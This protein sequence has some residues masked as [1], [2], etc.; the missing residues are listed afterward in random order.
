G[1]ETNDGVTY[2]KYLYEMV[3]DPATAPIKVVSADGTESYY[4]S[5]DGSYGASNKLK[6]GD[7]IVLL[8][9]IDL[10]SYISIGDEV[11][12]DLNGKKITNPYGDAINSQ[13]GDVTIVDNSTLKTGEIIADGKG[14]YGYATIKAGTITG[15]YA[16]VY[17]YN[18]VIEGGTFHGPMNGT[19]FI[20]GGDISDITIDSNAKIM[21]N[22]ALGAAMND[23]V[24][25]KVEP[26]DGT[27]DIDGE[28]WKTLT[29]TIYGTGDM[30][31]YYNNAKLPWQ[32]MVPQISNVVVEEGITSIGNNAL[33]GLVEVTEISI[34]STITKI[35]IYAFENTPFNGEFTV[36]ENV[37]TIGSTAFHNSMITA[38]AVDENNKHFMAANGVL[39]DANQMVL[40]AYPDAGEEFVDYIVPDTV[41]G[42]VTGAFLGAD[43]K[44]LT[45]PNNEAFSFKP[46]YSSANA[47]ASYNIGVPENKEDY[48]FA[49]WYT[50]AE[51]ENKIAMVA[52]YANLKDS[53]HGNLTAVYA[54]WIS[55]VTLDANGGAE[56]PAIVEVVLGKA[57]GTVYIPTREGYTFG[58][59][60]TKA[61]GS[62]TV[63]TENTVPDG[64]TTYYAVW[65]EEQEVDGV[66]VSFVAIPDME[67]TGSA[68]EPVVYYMNDAGE[69]VKAE[70]VVYE[71][72]TNVGEAS[73]KV[74]IEEKEFT[75]KF[76][77]TKATI[78]MSGVSF[79]N[80]SFAY[81]GEEHSLAIEGDLPEG[82]TVSYENNGRTDFGNQ[83]VT[84]KFT[85]SDNYEAVEDMTAKLSISR[86]TIKI[87]ADDKEIYVGEAVPELTY[88]VISQV[89][90]EPVDV[91]LGFEP[92]ITCS[93]NGTEAGTFAIK[94]SGDY[95]KNIGNYYLPYGVSGAYKNGTLSVIARYAVETAEA[96]NGEVSVLPVAAPQGQTVTI[97]A[98]PDNGYVV[99]KVTVLDAEGKEVAVTKGDDG[100][101]TFV[102]P[103]SKV[104]VSATFKKASQDTP[105]NPPQDT[106]TPEEPVMKVPGKNDTEPFTDVNE[107]D[108]F[109]DAVL[110][111]YVNDIT[112]GVSDT[113]FDPEAELTRGTFLTL[114]YRVDGEPMVSADILFEDVDDAKWYA[115]AVRWGTSLGIVSG[116]P[117]GSFKPDTVISRQEMAIMLYRYAKHLDIVDTDNAGDLSKFTDA[118]SIANGWSEKPAA[119]AKAAFEWAVG[120]GIIQGMGNDTLAPENTA[121]R[122]HGMQ[123]VMNLCMEYLMDK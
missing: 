7:T 43:L 105:V 13:Y 20:K 113:A 15:D 97:T 39:F 73:D 51:Y 103:E 117:D 76:N 54:K 118:D 53:D 72:N 35:G 85:V 111:A 1:Q 65:T 34:P 89:T 45:F 79:A 49:G 21:T 25:W 64:H 24:N 2:N 46:A 99:D 12:L 31:D 11:T 92:E 67:Y 5:F 48:R 23:T 36:P 4:N 44:S 75:L 109:Y 87:V 63:V 122:A 6:D 93:A 38:F 100:K 68:L 107:K 104:T 61:D 27:V 115:D 42:F 74:T 95:G 17:G 9:N 56:E 60:N 119:E 70:N 84:A 123:V 108:W 19:L 58:G 10:R 78:D 18:T 80:G 52:E 55:D 91:E 16:A 3:P 22:V 50:E 112:K 88:Q 29:L 120:A 66:T 57:L 101:Y 86:A 90:G 116:Y 30:A 98:T 69:Q 114:L 37:E 28:E 82:V 102:M 62:G 94:V 121:T 96:E 110:F 77:I 8:D 14:V 33:K 106:D 32:S 81:D 40:V 59:W 71:N 26:N 41:T 83:T 47:A